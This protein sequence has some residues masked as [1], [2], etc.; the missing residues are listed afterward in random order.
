MA[1]M[2]SQYSS[3]E[4]AERRKDVY[5]GSAT[6]A[7]LLGLAHLDANTVPGSLTRMREAARNT[8]LVVNGTPRPGT[9]K[10]VGA[11]SAMRPI[12]VKHLLAAGLLGTGA[13]AA[14]RVMRN[15]EPRQIVPT[16]AIALSKVASA[17]PGGSPHRDTD[18]RRLA[19]A[20]G[21]GTALGGAGLAGGGLIAINRSGYQR[22]LAETSRGFANRLHTR[23]TQ[24]PDAARAAALQQRSTSM[25]LVAQ[26]VY[27]RAKKLRRRGRIALGAGLG[28]TAGG[29]LLAHVA[30]PRRTGG[31]TVTSPSMSEVAKWARGDTPRS[32]RR[33]VVAGTAAAG[34]GAATAIGGQVAIQRARTQRDL[35]DLEQ[36]TAAKQKAA[37]R[38]TLDLATY[39]AN[40]A[41]K[42]RDRAMLRPTSQA[43]DAID[44]MRQAYNLMNSAQARATQA[45]GFH[46][47]S[48][49]RQT[50]ARMMYEGARK[51]HRRGLA[52][53]VGGTGA[54]V[55]GGAWAHH[56]EDNA[57]RT[58]VRKL[59]AT[60]HVS[61]PRRTWREV[62]SQ[63]FYGLPSHQVAQLNPQQRSEALVRSLPDPAIPLVAPK[64][65]KVAATTSQ[66]GASLKGGAIGTAAGAAAGLLAGGPTRWRAT[67]RTL[68]TMGRLVQRS[69]KDPS[70]VARQ[71][72]L[73]RAVRASR[74][75]VNPLKDPE[76]RSDLTRGAIGGLVTSQAINVSSAAQSKR[77]IARNPQAWEEQDAKIQRVVNKLSKAVEPD[78][79]PDGFARQMQAEAALRGAWPHRSGWVVDTGAAVVAVPYPDEQG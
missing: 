58:G 1:Q 23:S 51:L 71:A 12:G 8:E 14:R 57:R 45:K 55:L 20:V 43:T 24:I 52:A 15:N 69:A 31:P 46:D 64:G 78:V 4:R 7:G 5:L 74:P 2:R 34:L 9:A 77:T 27:D 11:L 50:K 10:M 68:R 48:T 67:G 72:R 66:L 70:Q 61:G 65:E 79:D 17:V 33:R 56:N 35:A 47:I 40:Q 39:Q 75:R 21:Q 19:Y 30:R 38:S 49:A 42:L 25:D 29:S 3:N 54:A 62:K 16:G 60:E 73:L 18:R 26:N 37:S 22:G 44:D 13:G 6:G 53:L 36:L 41:T 63:T 32:R 28:L 76:R 59:D